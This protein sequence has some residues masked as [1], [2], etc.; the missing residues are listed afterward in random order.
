MGIPLKNLMNEI[1]KARQTI[2]AVFR[3]IDETMK[4]L[5]LAEKVKSEGTALVQLQHQLGQLRRDLTDLL[6]HL[7]RGTDMKRESKA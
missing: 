5:P 3:A 1:G 4:P 6:T 2:D 7:E